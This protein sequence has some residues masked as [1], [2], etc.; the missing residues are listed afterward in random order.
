MIMDDKLHNYRSPLVMSTGIMLGFLFNVAASWALRPSTGSKF[1]EVVTASGLC[2]C[3]VLL[4][5]VL[6]RILDIHY[7]RETA[8]SYYKK[9]L[10]IYVVGIS[11]AFLSF[12]LLKMDSIY[13]PG[14]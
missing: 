8:D 1:R 9:T 6:Y 11:V 7:P 4:L 10:H 5:I 3:I 14:H 2:L 12:I 13:F